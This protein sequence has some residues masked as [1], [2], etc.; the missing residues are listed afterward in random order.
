MK[1]TNTDFLIEYAIIDSGIV[2]A[3]KLN[4]QHREDQ[5]NKQ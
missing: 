1:K 4:K 5:P 2:G 3:S